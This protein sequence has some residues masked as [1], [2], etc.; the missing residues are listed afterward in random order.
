M[1]F[2]EVRLVS[3]GDSL[4]DDIGEVTRLHAG[5]RRSGW[6][7]EAFH[8]TSIAMVFVA[9]GHLDGHLQ[10]RTTLWDIAG[11][12]VICS[13]AGLDVRIGQDLA[14]GIPWVAAGTPGLLAAAEPLWPEIVSP[15]RP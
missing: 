2:A 14:S 13:E 15:R 5:L 4:G 1:P 7:V 11:G 3:L 9:R 12:S 10:K 6:V 8:S